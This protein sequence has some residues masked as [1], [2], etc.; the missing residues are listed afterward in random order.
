MNARKEDSCKI[1][2]ELDTLIDYC[3]NTKN[4]DC[5]ALKH[6]YHAMAQRCGVEKL[7][8]F[9]EKYA[10]QFDQWVKEGQQYSART[11][12]NTGSK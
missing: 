12:G 1:A 6:A 10:G 5:T 4:Q 3:H 7:G 2:D 8:I 9:K 11:P